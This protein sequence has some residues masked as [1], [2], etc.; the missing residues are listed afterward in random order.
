MIRIFYLQ[1]QQ[2]LL[3]FDDEQ[4]FAYKDFPSYGLQIF[5]DGRVS[6]PAMPA[7]VAISN[8]IFHQEA[9]QE[10]AA[11]PALYEIWQTYQQWQYDINVAWQI[12]NSG[13]IVKNGIYGTNGYGVKVLDIHPKQDSMFMCHTWD[14]V[15]GVDETKSLIVS[16]Q[17]IT[18]MD[19]HGLAYPNLMYRPNA[20]KNT[21]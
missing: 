4:L 3:M 1:N 5:S 9:I 12:H 14:I 15:N 10:I 21:A 11:D 19:F 8:A 13:Q 7:P 6:L 18:E 20:S 2:N 16:I 17:Q